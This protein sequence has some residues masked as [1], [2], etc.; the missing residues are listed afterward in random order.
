MG[1]EPV[2]TAPTAPLAGAQVETSFGIASV[3]PAVIAGPANPADD[4]R[5]GANAAPAAERPTARPTKAVKPATGKP[6]TGKPANSKPAAGKPAG[7]TVSK[8]ADLRHAA[9]KAGMSTSADQ[10]AA[11]QRPGKAAKR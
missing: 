2:S 10:K 1:T 9:G 11:P 8:Q 3:E 5:I 6:A 4:R 7:R